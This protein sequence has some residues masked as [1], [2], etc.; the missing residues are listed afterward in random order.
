MY[1]GDPAAAVAAEYDRRGTRPES[2]EVDAEGVG[3]VAV[4]VE[5]QPVAYCRQRDLPAD[6]EVAVADGDLDTAKHPRLGVGEHPGTEGV[7][8]AQVAPDPG[9]LRRAGAHGVL[10]ES[11]D[12]AEDRAGD[13]PRRGERAE[14][15]GVGEGDHA[16]ALAGSEHQ[17]GV[18]TGPDPVVADGGVSADLAAAG[19]TSRSV[20]GLSPRER[21]T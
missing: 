6:N 8:A 3:V 11:E 1:G 5:A 16:G 2:G 12:A 7:P 17:G 20:T 14:R 18:E 10:G 21:S 19:T 13:W 9:L 15:P 4:G